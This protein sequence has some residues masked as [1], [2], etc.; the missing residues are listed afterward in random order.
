V[1]YVY[2]KR[3]FWFVSRAVTLQHNHDELSN[4]RAEQN[5]HKAHVIEVVKLLFKRWLA[6]RMAAEEVERDRAIGEEENNERRSR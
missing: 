2:C 5:K 1:W 4:Q 6:D 3:Y